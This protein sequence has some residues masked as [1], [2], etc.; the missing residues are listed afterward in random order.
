LYGRLTDVNFTRGSLTRKLEA[1]INGGGDTPP[2]FLFN[3]FDDVAFDAFPGLE[4][5]WNTLYSLG[6]REIHLAGSGPSLFAPVSRK[7]VGTALHLML[8]HQHGMEAYLV[9]TWHPAKEGQK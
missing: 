1:R 4:S 5:Y 2:Q 6:A 9:S 7:E 3:A 8:K